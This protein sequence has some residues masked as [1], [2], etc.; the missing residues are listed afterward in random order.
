MSFAAK[1]FYSFDS[2]SAGLSS[3]QTEK[4]QSGD[5]SAGKVSLGNNTSCG[6]CREIPDDGSKESQA[7]MQLKMSSDW[8]YTNV[9][10]SIGLSS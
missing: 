7:L 6:T 3:W 5:D 8:S 9:A 10:I 1:G 2:R 4:Q